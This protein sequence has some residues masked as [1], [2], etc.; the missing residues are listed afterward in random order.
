[1]DSA[2]RTSRNV[3]LGLRTIRRRITSGA[4]TA[5]SRPTSPA[6]DDPTVSPKQ[7]RDPRRSGRRRS[8]RW[9]PI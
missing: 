5:S 4:T 6:V 8:R 7:E 3:I 9:P 1:M 2:P